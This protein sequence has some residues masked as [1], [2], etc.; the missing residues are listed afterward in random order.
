MAIESLDEYEEK[1]VI[2]HERYDGDSGWCFDD[3]ESEERIELGAELTD[4]RV[5]HPE[6]FD[7]GI[8]F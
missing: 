5:E 7:D 4:F 2:Y 8:P 6:C 1:L 3:E